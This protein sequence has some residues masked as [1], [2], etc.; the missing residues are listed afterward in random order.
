MAKVILRKNNKERRGLRTRKGMYGTPSIPR[1][2]VNRTNRYAFAQ[3]VDD[4]KGK[5]LVSISLTEVKKLHENKTKTVASYD[6]G[7]E[8]AEKAKSSGIKKV[9]FDKGSYKYHGRVKSLADGARNGG[10]VL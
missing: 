1:L 6:V 8:L 3:I 9:V 10:L 5:T 7:K 4:S 2:T